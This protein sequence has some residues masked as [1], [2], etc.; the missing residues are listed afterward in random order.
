LTLQVALPGHMVGDRTYDTV[1]LADAL[2]G[3][4]PLTVGKMDGVCSPDHSYRTQSCDAAKKRMS[5]IVVVPLPNGDLALH[6]SS[7][8]TAEHHG[9][10]P[11]RLRWVA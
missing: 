5:E 11:S 3:D 10:G 9:Y 7:Q 4:S 8:R 6:L 2:P 1:E